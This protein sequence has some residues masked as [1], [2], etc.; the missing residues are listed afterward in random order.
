MLAE[1]RDALVLVAYNP[2]MTIGGLVLAA[3]QAILYLLVGRPFDTADGVLAVPDLVAIGAVQQVWILFA[4]FPLAGLYALC[5]DALSTVEHAQ[6]GALERDVRGAVSRFVAAGRAT[7]VPLL[8]AT[9]LY[10]AVAVLVAIGIAAAL[11]FVL[12]VGAANGVFSVTPLPVDTLSDSLVYVTGG[13]V[14]LALSRVG[15]ALPFRF[16]DLFLLFS[17][18]APTTSWATS[19]RFA[20]NYPRRLLEYGVVSAVPVLVP[21]LFAF[22]MRVGAGHLFHA[23]DSF[24]DA[25]AVGSYVLVGSI[26]WTLAGAYHVIF[27]DRVVEPAVSPTGPDGT[28]VLKSVLREWVPSLGRA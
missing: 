19:A 2:V 28:A 15:G 22:G 9:V 3:M 10:K 6:E 14:L 25:V 26:G 27:F 8:A 21:V 1:V 4:P 7:Y 5:R 11:D 17:R 23:G 18:D 13:A 12:F 20:K 24:L 16:Y